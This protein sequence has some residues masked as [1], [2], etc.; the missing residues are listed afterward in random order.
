MHEDVHVWCSTFKKPVIA[1]GAG[2]LLLE[3]APSAPLSL[4]S[5]R[6]CCWWLMELD[7][8]RKDYE[9][10]VNDWGWLWRPNH[11]QFE[12][13]MKICTSTSSP[14]SGLNAS[15]SLHRPQADWKG[16]STSSTW[17]YRHKVITTSC[18]A[19][20]LI[21][22]LTERGKPWIWTRRWTEAIS[23]SLSIILSHD[24]RVWIRSA[25][26]SQRSQ[27]SQPK[28]QVTARPEDLESNA[29][30]RRSTQSK[31]SRASR[32]SKGSNASRRVLALTAGCLFELFLDRF[33]WFFSTPL[34]LKIGRYTWSLH[35]H[36]N[37]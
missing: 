30:S 9:H 20:N 7:G 1:A 13:F 10:H 26:S 33:C 11:K 28:L 16:I 34:W 2:T 5:T 6:S 35:G 8:K 19:A 25:F 24:W 4:W 22:L 14:Q 23:D 29:G 27:L 17:W 32:A 12:D 31:A 3:K 21:V 36:S 15:V 37:R 18:A